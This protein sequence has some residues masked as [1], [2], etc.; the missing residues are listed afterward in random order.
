MRGSP[1]RK[2]GETPTQER[3]CMEGAVF[4][5]YGPV[6]GADALGRR[7]TARISKSEYIRMICLKTVLFGLKRTA[8]L[9]RI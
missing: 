4:H 5:G 2:L 9:L 1:R 6:T 8:F 7:E 3:C